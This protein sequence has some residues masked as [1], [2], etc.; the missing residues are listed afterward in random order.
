MQWGLWKH[1]CNVQPQVTCFHYYWRKFNWFVFTNVLT[2]I[3]YLPET[4]TFYITFHLPKRYEIWRCV[5][6]DFR[7]NPKSSCRIWLKANSSVYFSCYPQLPLATYVTPWQCPHDSM[8]K[9]TVL[10]QN[11]HQCLRPL[12]SYFPLA[13]VSRAYS[14]KTC[15]SNLKISDWQSK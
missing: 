15:L 1:S 7:Q 5:E 8:A 3:I 6:T 11:Q 2:V 12:H 14:R 10:G 13:L 4:L 9:W